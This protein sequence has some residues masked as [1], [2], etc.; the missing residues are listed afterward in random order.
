MKKKKNKVND[1]GQM[2]PIL[3]MVNTILNAKEELLSSAMQC[4]SYFRHMIKL[5]TFSKEDMSDPELRL[6]KAAK[7]WRKI[8]K[9]ARNARKNQ[10]NSQSD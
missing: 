5:E 3:K 1:Y 6:M 4:D 9:A 10:N 8:R 2:T 7:A